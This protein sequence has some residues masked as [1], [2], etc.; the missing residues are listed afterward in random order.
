MLGCQAQLVKEAEDKADKEL[1]VLLSD[2]SGLID[3]AN[4]AEPKYGRSK[5]NP[6]P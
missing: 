5:S 1:D 2:L 4:R 3:E 6:I